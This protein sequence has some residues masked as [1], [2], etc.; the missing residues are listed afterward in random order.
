MS[1]T[2]VT[3]GTEFTLTQILDAPVEKVWRVWTEP[4]H[5]AQWFGAHPDSVAIDLRPGGKWAATMATPQGDFPMGGEYEEV[6]HHER[7]VWNMAFPTGTVVMSATF[8]DRGAQTEA[9]YH[10]ACANEEEL[11]M[12]SEG[13]Q[14][15]MTSL[16][17]Y[18]KTV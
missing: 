17:N 2:L 5:F 6:V 14:Q 3:N 13:A 15:L 12:A 16:A 10:Q 9:A 11:A 1:Q 8:T 18:L 4:A 7:L